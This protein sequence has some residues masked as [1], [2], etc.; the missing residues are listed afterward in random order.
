MNSSDI[1]K[2]YCNMMR[3]TSGRFRSFATGYNRPKVDIDIVRYVL[4]LRIAHGNQP[5]T[6][7]YSGYGLAA[8]ER[9]EKTRGL[10]Q[11]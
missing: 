1:G 2:K 4:S 3:M 9:A 8:G 5:N 7:F 10:S 6:L 11:C